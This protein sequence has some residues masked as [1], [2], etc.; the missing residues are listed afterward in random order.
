MALVF[1]GTPHGGGN[2]AATAKY[3]ANIASI[4]TGEPRNNLLSALKCGSLYNEATIDDFNPQI[5]SYDVVSFFETRKTNVKI[6]GWRLLLQITS[7]VSEPFMLHQMGHLTSSFQLVVDV[8]AAKLGSPSELLLGIDSTHSDMCRFSA[9]S[10]ESGKF[11]PIRS[12]LVRMSEKSRNQNVVGDP[13]VDV[14]QI[15]PPPL[16]SQV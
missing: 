2:R 9:D 12:H 10:E 5:G 7:M 3:V 15:P 14:Q 6:R 8:Q 16:N 13:P 11:E 4:F 1:F